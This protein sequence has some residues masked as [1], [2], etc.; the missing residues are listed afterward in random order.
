VKDT[1]VKS[2]N[3]AVLMLVHHVE[4]E[5]I[6]LEKKL[7]MDIKI[8]QDEESPMTESFLRGLRKINPFIQD[9]YFFDNEYTLK[10]GISSDAQ[11]K[12]KDIKEWLLNRIRL[13]MKKRKL[14]D[15]ELRHLSEDYKG[16][17]IQVGYISLLDKLK[18]KP[19][20]YLVF[21][22]NIDY[23]KSELLAKEL[24]KLNDRI[25]YKRVAIENMSNPA[26]A[27]DTTNN[28]NIRVEIPFRKLF[29][30]WK[31]AVELDTAPMEQRAHMEMIA[32]SGIIFI[33]M[34]LFG[35]SIFLT[36]RYVHHERLLSQT[37]SEMV[38]HVSHELKTPLALIRMYAETLMLGRLSHEQKKEDYYTIIIHECE[39][40][41][42]L[43]NNILDFASIEKGIKEYHFSKG[44]LSQTLKQMFESYS[45]YIRQNGFDLRLK[46][47][48]VPLFNFDKMAMIQ[49]ILN[50]LD[51]A[52]KFSTDTKEIEVNLKKQ[53]RYAIINVSDKGIGIHQKEV[54]LIFEPFYRI[55]NKPLGKGIGLSLVKHTVE[56]HGGEV[57]VKSEVGRGST[58]IITL[59]IRG[60]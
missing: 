16:I 46:I 58:F 54:N 21:S 44:H 5:I 12:K 15:L 30:F 53:D 42:L 34:G 17:P 32:Y 28:L 27:D 9:M 49:T 45:Y 33:V 13:D 36:F 60:T 4:N 35:I 41:N 29:T 6:S 1:V 48:D 37:K 55:S 26:L 14:V 52:M 47:D 56:A 40:L 23:F 38:S 10:Y 24:M 8:K 39:R 43:I 22:I 31:I 59:P 25:H 20:G 51:N 50:L 57:T 2:A 3:I 18:K 19:S 7:I 11:L